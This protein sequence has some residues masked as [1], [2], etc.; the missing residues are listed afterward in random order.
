M[1][2]LNTVF[3]V[4][5]HLYPSYHLSL[6]PIAHAPTRQDQKFLTHPFWN[7]PT[8][9][10]AKDTDP[11]KRLKDFFACLLDLCAFL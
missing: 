8:R 6:A 10:P 2:L 1:L 5:E 3:R 11:I 9:F 7:A 4:F